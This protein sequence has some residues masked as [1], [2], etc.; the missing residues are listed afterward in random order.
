MGSLKLVQV[1]SPVRITEWVDERG[2][3]T[4]FFYQLILDLWNR[5]GGAV[6]TGVITDDGLS[7]IAELT[8][9]ANNMIYTT[10]LDTYAV[11]TLTPFARTILDDADEATF[12]ATV[13]LEIGTDVQAFDAG[14]LSI[15]G[16]S[17]S[18]DNLIYTT[19][20]D[21]YATADI[22]AFGR[23]LID[24]A[25]AAAGR[26]T[27]ELGTIS[28][29]AANNVSITGGA[30][31]GTP[32]GGSTA[33]AGTFTTLSANSV[34]A[35][36]GN[37]TVTGSSNVIGYATGAGGTVTQMTDRTTGVT[38]NRPS[39]AIT[40]VSAAGTTSWQ[41]F[42]VTNSVVAATDTIIVNQKSGTDL[43]QIHVT[44]VA[45]GS[46]DITFA[47]TGG[48]TTEQPVFNFAV[49]KGVAA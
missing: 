44:A 18:A 41:T 45:A 29:Q 22:T 19:A 4:R 2:H 10:A 25:N 14:L 43:N 49:L 11:A 39:G 24:D 3:P 17:T 7:S 37:I 9:A 34:T 13:N 40:L 16:L 15:A 46:F 23:S 26:T 20:S 1:D 42:T 47:T 31:D 33:D 48:T 5:V 28:T 38:L 35:T 21:T 12:K 27:L 8:T 30:I 32:V 36:A 6:D